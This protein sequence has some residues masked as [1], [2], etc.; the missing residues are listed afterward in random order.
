MKYLSLFLI[1]CLFTLSPNDQERK[2]CAVHSFIKYIVLLYVV[3]FQET[4]IAQWAKHCF[5]ATQRK[6]IIAPQQRSKKTVIAQPPFSP[7][8]F[9]L[10]HS[11][12]LFR[13]LWPRFSTISFPIETNQFWVALQFLAGERQAFVCCWSAEC[14]QWNIIRSSGNGAS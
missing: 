2:D 7:K 3:A 14:K 8:S 9:N 1:P 11:V 13:W 4:Q 12:P 10:Q 5:G 6:I